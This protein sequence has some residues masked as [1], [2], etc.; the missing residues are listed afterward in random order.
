M[1]VIFWKL[2]E[3]HMNVYLVQKEICFDYRK[4]PWIKKVE[5]ALS[6]NGICK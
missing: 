1:V 5:E 4:F 3:N 6:R 2:G